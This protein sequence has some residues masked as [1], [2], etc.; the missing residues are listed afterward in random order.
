VGLLNTNSRGVFIK[1][2]KKPN[3]T[4]LFHHLGYCHDIH[5]QSPPPLHRQFDDG[6]VADDIA[7]DEKKSAH[8]SA[9]LDAA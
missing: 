3:L 2:V 8:L 9:L 1:I 5:R 7:V 6:S 4:G